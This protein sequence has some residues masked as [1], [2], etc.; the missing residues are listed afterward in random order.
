MEGTYFD[1]GRVRVFVPSGWK[2]FLGIDSEGRPDAKKLHIFKDA[3]IETDIFIKAG[4]TVCYFSKGE[5]FYS[6]KGFYDEV[7]DI[8]PKMIGE[9]TFEGYTCK[10]IGY[11]YTMLDCFEDGC[12]IHVMILEKN[13][14]HSI[15]LSD[16]DVIDVISSIEVM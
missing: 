16:K 14:D 11:P 2:A 13:G 1:T 3:T 9:R 15:S 5:Y 12:V 4:I 7:C 8:E 6:P 10:S